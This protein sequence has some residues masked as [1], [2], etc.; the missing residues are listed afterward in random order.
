MPR[1]CLASAT[2]L[3]LMAPP[4][5]GQGMNAFW[6]TCGY[7]NR[8]HTFACDTNT[9][10]HDL[11]VSFAPPTDMPA[12]SQAFGIIDLCLGGVNLTPWW[13][14]NSGSCRQG[15]LSAL[16]EDVSGSLACADHW[17]GQASTTV[18]YNAGYSGWDSARIVVSVWMDEQFAPPVQAGTEYHAFTVRIGNESTVGAGACGGCT[19]PACIVLNELQIKQPAGTPGG[20][21]ILTNPIPGGNNYLMWQQSVPNCPF[22]VPVANRTWGQIK[23]LYR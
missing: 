16:A 17:Q 5:W 19:F 21:L 12:V 1:A 4:V 14:Y 8:L 18:Y 7:G 15:A 6:G 11:V 10:N 9:G 2:W 20:D 3:F 13:Q 23:S 22:I